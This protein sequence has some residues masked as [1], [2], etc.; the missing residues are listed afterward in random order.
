MIGKNGYK[1]KKIILLQSTFSYR[2]SLLNY[3]IFGKEM[4]GPYWL[5]RFYLNEIKHSLSSI[6]LLSHSLT[7]N[8]VN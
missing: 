8:E 1:S 4:G 3:Q 7:Y 5:I 6:T 2:I